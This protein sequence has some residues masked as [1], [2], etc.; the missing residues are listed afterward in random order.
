MWCILT[1]EN[2]SAIQKEGI[3]AVCDNPDG[4]EDTMLSEVSQSQKD[5]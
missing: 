4:P 3:S 1:M 5:K 2:Y